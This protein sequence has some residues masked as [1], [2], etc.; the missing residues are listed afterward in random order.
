MVSDYRGLAFVGLFPSSEGKWFQFQNVCEHGRDEFWFGGTG[1]RGDLSILLDGP[2]HETFGN[3]NEP[4]DDGLDSLWKFQT[5]PWVGRLH[6][7]P[8]GTPAGRLDF[9]Q[10]RSPGKATAAK[11]RS[12]SR[13]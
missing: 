9:L 7:Q 5:L 2:V 6:G 10:A 4:P 12:Q 1:E 13:V 8:P 11:G 3:P